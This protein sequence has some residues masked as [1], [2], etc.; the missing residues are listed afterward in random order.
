MQKITPPLLPR[1]SPTTSPHTDFK[2]TP[3]IPTPRTPAP[4][5]PAISNGA[6]AEKVIDIGRPVTP[7]PE[8]LLVH[9]N[10]DVSMMSASP[11]SPTSPSEAP[12]PDD[13]SQITSVVRFVLD[14][15][16]ARDEKL[17]IEPYY[18]II[19]QEITEERD[20]W[21][22]KTSPSA[23]REKETPRE[24]E[25]GRDEREREREREKVRDRRTYTPPPTTTRAPFL[26][27]TI[28]PDSPPS[29]RA[30]PPLWRD[31]E[32]RSYGAASGNR[33]DYSPQPPNTRNSGSRWETDRSRD[34]SPPTA[35]RG[36]GSYRRGNDR[37][38]DRSRDRSPPSRGEREERDRYRRDDRTT[39]RPRY[40]R[41]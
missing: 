3:T 2:S 17:T 31:G 19:E 4:S 5:N 38:R 30:S 14:A 8:F 26:K 15:S 10:E 40:Y 11:T 37:E 6:P 20:L 29:R 32:G 39:D 36:G 9:K 16:R 28:R 1:E 12:N 13:P 21:V 22:P 23:T 24:K 27:H 34:R 33:R 18:D 25:R 7:P 41:D 35:I